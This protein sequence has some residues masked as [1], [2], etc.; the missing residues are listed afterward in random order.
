MI[1]QNAIFAETAKS[2][3]SSLGLNLNSFLTQLAT[4]VIVLLILRK[5]VFPKL[6]ATIEKRRL[7][8]EESLVQAKKTEETLAKAEQKATEILHRARE[9]ADMALKDAK[10]QG[11]QL[12]AQAEQTAGA[13]AQKI[14]DQAQEQLE[15]DRQRLHRELRSE[16]AELV[17]LTTEHVLDKK[18]D[19]K[20][21]MELINRQV[22]E[23]AR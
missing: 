8:L 20:T 12:V 2:G 6:V 10:K 19:E 9:E 17:A 11:E 13:K 21:D 3:I 23:L 1:N 4:F 18:L 7:T 15:I 5:W 16:L 22:K 14:I